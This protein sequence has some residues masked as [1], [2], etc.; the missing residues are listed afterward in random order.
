LTARQRSTNVDWGNLTRPFVTA[1]VVA[2]GTVIFAAGVAYTLI[3]PITYQS[4]ASMVLAPAPTDPSDLP[5]VLDSFQRSGTAGTYVELLASEDTKKR[6]G[7]PPVTLKVSSVPD[8]RVIRISST[9][10]DKNIVQPA[11]RSVLVAAN[12]E[13][14]RL[15]DLWQLRTLQQPTAPSQ[16]STGSGLI[17]IASLLLA[18]LG[19]LS[20]WTLLRRYG[21]QSDRM[22]PRRPPRD[23]REPREPR[24]PD[25]AAAG[26]LTREGPRYPTSR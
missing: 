25:I 15:E 24:E 2:V 12:R 1:V 13:Q 3:R 18:I 21:T 16:A 5:G 7:S 8:T 19:A 22:P 14:S 9:A 26:W 11:L 23:P 6:A 17:L 20:A 4:D 10:G